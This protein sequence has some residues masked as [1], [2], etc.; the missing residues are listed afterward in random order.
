VFALSGWDLVGALTLPS[1]AVSERLADGDTRWIN[2][3]AYD[4]IGSNS[5]AKTSAA[6]LPVTAALYG[7]LPKQLASADSFASRLARMLRVRAG[8]R[9][10]AGQLID[11]PAVRAKGLLLLVHQLP[12]SPDL[13]VTAVNFGALPV[14]ESVVIHGAAPDSAASD[15]LD[16]RAP[17]LTLGAGGTLEVHLAA[18]EGRAYRVIGKREREKGTG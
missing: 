8:L 2:R 11:A 3:G 15:L 4:L 12:D 1:A 6:G 17:Q 13:E 16:D 5:G 18:Y 10:Y 14:A 9:L 7:A